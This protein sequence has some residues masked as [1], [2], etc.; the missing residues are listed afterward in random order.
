MSFLKTLLAT[1]LGFFIS[2]GIM[3][4]IFLVTISVLMASIGGNSSEGTKVES[5]TILELDFKKPLTDYGEKIVIEDFD[6]TSQDYNGL[7]AILKAI[8]YAKTDDRIKGINIKSSGNIGGVAFAKELRNALNDFKKSGKFVFAY[9]DQIPQLD[10]Y[11]QSIADKVFLNPQGELTLRGLSS[12]VL[13]YKGLQ[14]K[15]GVQ[16]EVIRHGKYKSAVEPFLSN[17]MSEENR[18]QIT[19]LLTS[20]WN[21][22]ATDIAQ[23]RNLSV[24]RLNAI[25]TNLEART[26]EGA[27][28]SGLVDE[29]LYRDEF[30]KK[31]CEKTGTK[32]ID[33]LH[34]IGIEAYAES[35]ANKSKSAASKD[36]IAVIYA[37]GDIT[38]GKGRGGVVGDETIITSLR[39]AVDNKHVKAIVLRINSPGGSALA[40]ELMHRE[41]ELTKKKKKVY[42][43]MG[44]YAASGGYYI[45]CNANRIFAEKSTIT[46]SIGVFGVIPNV[47]KL[48][49]NWGINAETVSTHP[50]AQQYSVFEKPSESFIKEMTEGIER[51]YKLFVSRV[52][53]GRGMTTAQVDSLAQGRVWSG[54][55]AL[56]KGLVDEIGSLN[57][58]LA[59]AAKQNGISSYGI[60]TYPTYKLSFQDLIDRYTMKV[61]SQSIKQ[62][63][64][65][66]AY[67]LYENLHKL[68]EQ[69]GVQ[70]RIYYDIHLE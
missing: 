37:D 11:L 40:S 24:E 17:T 55:E 51:T 41:I 25:A 19:E 65:N 69:Q 61:K 33:D 6:Y 43:S 68:S 62:E 1:I 48:A 58:A 21:S 50:H 54:E 14:E 22:I 47:H 56:K 20:V 38:Y 27:K 34:F 9:N 36:K 53:A 10:Y 18:K 23:S 42:V 15:T 39:K 46:G 66:E 16:M 32:S 2:L 8:E 31:L 52:A 30:E 12:E 13:F 64:G 28:A 3:F 35:V 57:D 49:E 4:V 29:L 59:Y 67:K 60:V 70:A 63:V 44:N 45:A 7:N 26:P 5:N